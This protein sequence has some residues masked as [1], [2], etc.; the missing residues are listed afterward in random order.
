M[1]LKLLL[2][3]FVV[4]LS[5][6]QQRTCGMELEMRN[7]MADPVLRQQHLERQARF[8]VEYQKLLAQK[9]NNKNGNV[10]NSTNATIRIPVA[11][12]FPSISASSTQAV[13]DCFRAF[14][15][16]QINIINADY[17]ATND[18]MANWA[19]ASEF[20]PGINVGNIDV[21]FVIATQNHPA[22]TGIANG[23][24]A[25]TFGTDFLN[26]SYGCSNGCNNDA[27]WAGY[28]NFVIKN[29]GNGLLGYSNLGGSPSAGGSVVMNTFCY[30]SGPG[31][32]A[33][34]TPTA[35]FNL[36]RTVTHELGH[37]F[38]LDHTF[39]SDDPDATSCAGPDADGIADTPKVAHASYGCP[40]PGEVGACGG[41]NALTMNYMD[42]V[43]DACMYMFT[44][45]QQIRMLAYLNT[46]IGQYL[47]NVLGNNEVLV[48]NFSIAPN[49]N[50]GTFNIQLKDV[51]DY[52]IEVFDATG[53]TVLENNYNQNNELNQEVKLYDA[54]KGVYFVSIKSQDAVITKKIIVE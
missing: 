27:T 41:D 44:E 8:Q 18:D 14:A 22:G 29:I 45:G 51:M 21:E 39:I 1:K 53:R 2:A 50:K 49:P 48:N 31:C 24:P 9:A 19:T 6:A 33:L 12:H 52:S 25:V 26:A 11:V 37:F 43:D 20:Y 35:P 54:A 46:I 40:G 17:N 10:T 34:Y 16:T 23:S 5:F 47:T 36:G 13:K 4:Q 38:N 42:Y 32:T 28:M 7:I 15:Q 3:L 30:G